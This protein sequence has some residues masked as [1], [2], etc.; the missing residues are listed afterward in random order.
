MLLFVVVVVVVVVDRYSYVKLFYR[1]IKIMY[2]FFLIILT[3]F[4]YVVGHN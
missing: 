4:V 2:Q 3:S 1:C